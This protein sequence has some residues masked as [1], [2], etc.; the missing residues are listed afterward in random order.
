MN[1]ALSKF[2]TVMIALFL[3]SYTG[4]QAFRYI[5]TSYRTENAYRFEVARSYNTHG[6]LLRG[7]TV[8]DQQTNGVVRYT[9]EEGHKFIPDTPIATVYSSQEAAQAAEERDAL[10]RELQTLQGIKQST[11][12][13]ELAELSLL[14]NDVSVTLRQLTADGSLGRVTDMEGSRLD[15]LEAAGRRQLITGEEGD[16]DGRIRTLAQQMPAVEEGTPIYC[17]RIG[18]FSRFVD[19]CEEE[20]SPQLLETLDGDT[21]Q[22]MLEQEYPYDTQAFGKCV[23]SYQWYYVTVIPLE[24]AEMFQE[25]ADLTITFVGSTEDPVSGWVE[26]VKEEKEKNQAVLV[27]GSTDV[28]GDTVSRRTA[29]VKLG[30]SDYEGVRFSRQALRIQDGKKGVFVKGNSAVKFKQVDIVYTGK[31]F[32]LSKLDYSSDIYLNIF[33]VIIV[34]GND[35]YDGKPLEQGRY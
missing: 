32:Y 25:G 15:L 19:H 33:D 4:Y 24:D 26:Q 14:N 29:S 27:I 8:I 18:Y 5:Y 12:P 20:F 21:V 22:Q 3:L 30:F 17:N 34:E 11:N 31:D 9:L 28:N 35:L 16:L 1:N 13:D 23:N 7:E 2:M 6:I 10:Q